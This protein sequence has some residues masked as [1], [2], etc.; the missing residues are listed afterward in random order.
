[1]QQIVDEKGYL[2][3]RAIEEEILLGLACHDQVIATGGSA[4][5]SD[6]AMAHLKAGGWVVFLDLPLVALEARVGNFF[7]RGLARR[8]DQSFA[9]LF[10]ERSPL[11]RRYADLTI[12]CFGLR[13]EQICAR[14]CERFR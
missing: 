13:P 14:I 2:A 1:L 6:A 8:L 10:A 11:Y 4:V 3:L 7:S 5:Y 12:D 9:E